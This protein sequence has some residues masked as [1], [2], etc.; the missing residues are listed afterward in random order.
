[1]EYAQPGLRHP[2]YGAKLDRLRARQAEEP[3]R[4]LLLVLGTS[5]SGI[6][7][8]A[9]LFRDLDRATAARLSFLMSTPIIAGAAAKKAWD[10]HKVGGLPPEMHEPFIVGIIVSG[11]TGCLF[12][13]PCPAAMGPWPRRDTIP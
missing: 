9:G 11:L 3:G 13:R 10:L 8:A 2:V 7:M 12:Q 5:R 1:M 6:T 4:P